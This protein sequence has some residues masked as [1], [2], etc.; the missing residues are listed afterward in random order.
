MVISEMVFLT[1]A[2]AIHM[3]PNKFKKFPINRSFGTA[4]TSSIIQ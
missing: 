3:V 2:N 1:K 4:R